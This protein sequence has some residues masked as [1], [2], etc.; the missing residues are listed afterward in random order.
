MISSFYHNKKRL[1]L[2]NHFILFALAIVSLVVGGV[3]Y[4]AFRSLSLR[5]FDWCNTLGIMPLINDLRSMCDNIH[6]GH[7]VLYNLP[8]LLWITS[9]L[10]FVNAIIPKSDRKV[11]LFWVLLMPTLAICHEIMQGIGVAAGSFD[12]IDLLFYIIPLIINFLIINQ[13]H[14]CYEKD[15]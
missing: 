9:Y 2:L 6:P 15:F 7:F 4:L 13:T 1:D 12:I 11:Y 3:I 10:L 14:F 8:D 5:M